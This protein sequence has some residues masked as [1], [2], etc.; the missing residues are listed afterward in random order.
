MGDVPSA[1]AFVPGRITHESYFRRTRPPHPTRSPERRAGGSECADARPTTIRSISVHS[2]LNALL[3]FSNQRVR[4]RGRDQERDQRF[5]VSKTANGKKSPSDNRQAAA[6]RLSSPLLSRRPRRPLVL[7]QSFPRA[8]DRR[9]VEERPLAHWG[10]E[11]GCVSVSIRPRPQTVGRTRD[12][13][14]ARW[15][16]LSP[17]RERFFHVTHQPKGAVL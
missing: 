11:N 1:S 15:N 2:A 4:G 12:G 13:Q 3:S 17:P 14:P 10:G 9:S 7:R 6:G 16:E 8:P 5:R